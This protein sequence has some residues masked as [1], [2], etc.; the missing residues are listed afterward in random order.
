MDF[1]RFLIVVHN[2]EAR[3]NENLESLANCLNVIINAALAKEF[4]LTQSSAIAHL[5]LTFQKTVE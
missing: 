4:V 2:W 3:L 5:I 1:A